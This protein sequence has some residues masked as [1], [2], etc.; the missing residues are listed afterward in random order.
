MLYDEQ[1]SKLFLKPMYDA[2]LNV[3]IMLYCI[4]NCVHYS[5]WA[6]FNAKVHLD[7]CHL[8]RLHC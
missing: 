7:I 1:I 6:T 2:S 3:N 8:H 5:S 4:R